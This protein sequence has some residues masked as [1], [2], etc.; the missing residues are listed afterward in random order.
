MK[1]RIAPW[2]NMKVVNMTELD[3]EAAL[4]LQVETNATDLLISKRKI[5][6]CM[7]RIEG[8]ERKIELLEGKGNGTKENRTG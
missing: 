2:R 3:K 7:D 8:L 6:V 1:T 4:R 5:E